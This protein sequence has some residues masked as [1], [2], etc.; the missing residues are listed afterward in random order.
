M[1]PDTPQTEPPA[2]GKRA[3]LTAHAH[4]IACP[5][6]TVPIHGSCKRPIRISP[7]PNRGPVRKLTDALLRLIGR[8][9]YLDPFMRKLCD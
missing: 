3:T 4:P 7:N 2:I 8:D 9:P 6:I 1:A 5:G